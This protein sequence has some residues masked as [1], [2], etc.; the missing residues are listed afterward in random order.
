M[1]RRISTKYSL[2]KAIQIL[3]YCVRLR[4]ENDSRQLLWAVQWSALS[5]LH[6]LPN[7]DIGVCKIVTDINWARISTVQ[8]CI[9]KTL[10]IR[11]YPN[12][13]LLQR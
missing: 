11:Y 12:D 13:S 10:G 1:L 3:E 5:D 8:G 9:S 7:L 6:P 2:A 4:I